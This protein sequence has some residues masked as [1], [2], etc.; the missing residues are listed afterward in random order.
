MTTIEAKLRD[1]TDATY[2]ELGHDPFGPAVGDA[3]R[4]AAA[5]ALDEAAEI[6]HALHGGY[7]DSGPSIIA[8]IEKRAAELRGGR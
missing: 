4:S 8:A 7:D 6:A 1:L 3:I 2:A 5:L